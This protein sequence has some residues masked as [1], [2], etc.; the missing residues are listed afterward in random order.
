M[1][2][3]DKHQLYLAAGQAGWA[4]FDKFARGIKNQMNLESGYG[5]LSSPYVF[6]PGGGIR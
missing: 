5:D 2:I 1:G 4:E 3:H 6:G